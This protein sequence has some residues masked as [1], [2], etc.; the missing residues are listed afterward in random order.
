MV[1]FG[2]YCSFVT[3]IIVASEQTPKSL[4]YEDCCELRKYIETAALKGISDTTESKNQK[5]EIPP[6]L[7]ILSAKKFLGKILNG[8]YIVQKEDITQLLTVLKDENLPMT[9]CFKLVSWAIDT[10]N[11]EVFNI[12][13]AGTAIAALSRSIDT[14]NKKAIPKV[15]SLLHNLYQVEQKEASKHETHKLWLLA[16][17]HEDQDLRDI[18]QKISTK[19]GTTNPIV[20]NKKRRLRV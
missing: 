2:I 13:Q 20:S 11:L 8:N 19:R 4:T 12:M 1:L 6:N 10:E 5:L 3:N 18:L 9:V 14:N 7:G 15:K 17:R 16:N